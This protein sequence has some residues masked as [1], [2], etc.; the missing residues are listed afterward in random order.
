MMKSIEL[1]IRGRKVVDV[2]YRPFL[3]L[4]AMNRGIQKFYAFNS[5]TKGKEFVVLHVQGEDD[6]I[7][8][9]IDFIR[10]QY[11]EQAE[12]EEIVE[13]EFLGPVEDIDK[14]VQLLQFEQISKAIPI[15]LSLDQKQDIMIGKQDIMIGKQDIMI[16]KQDIMIGKQDIMIGKQDIMIEQQDKTINILGEVKEDTAAIRDDISVLRLDT[17]ESLHEK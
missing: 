8:S 4:N 6:S 2:G 14:F 16:G 9:Y 7:T 11:P 10:S 1:I 15:L 13:K 3:L 12:V 17:L 5:G